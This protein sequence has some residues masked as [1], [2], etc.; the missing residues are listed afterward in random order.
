MRANISQICLSNKQNKAAPAEPGGSE[1]VASS[2]CLPPSLACYCYYYCYHIT[3]S[4]NNIRQAETS[5]LCLHPSTSTPTNLQRCEMRPMMMITK[6]P[7]NSTGLP[8]PAL[9]RLLMLVHVA[10]MVPVWEHA[11][12]C[13]RAQSSPRMMSLLDRGRCLVL[14]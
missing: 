5:A 8:A 4:T 11:V 1:S 3:T 6:Q 9:A 14:T 12:G 2:A 7:S 13:Y 10:C